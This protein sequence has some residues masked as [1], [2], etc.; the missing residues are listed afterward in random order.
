M[1]LPITMLA[2]IFAAF[3]APTTIAHAQKMYRCGTTFSQTPCATDAVE[4][5][6]PGAGSGAGT[7]AAQD[8][9]ANPQHDVCAAAAI[10]ATGTLEPETARVRPRGKRS[11]ETMEYAGQTLPVVRVDVDVS[12]KNE[13]GMFALNGSVTCWLSEDRQRILK[14]SPAR[15]PHSMP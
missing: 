13:H 9:A 15:G 5:R 4:K 6:L 12:A 14:M 3:A 10:R 11:M 1:R 7:G 2:L 8:D